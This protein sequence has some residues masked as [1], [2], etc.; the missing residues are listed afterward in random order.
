MVGATQ[1]LCLVAITAICSAE[2]FSLKVASVAV[3]TFLARHS[4][5]VA[6]RCHCPPIYSPPTYKLAST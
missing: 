2:R 3:A 4:A 5:D 6:I 1:L